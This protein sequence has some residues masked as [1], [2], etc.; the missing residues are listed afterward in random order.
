MWEVRN[1]DKGRREWRRITPTY[2]GSTLVS[3]A[4]RSP[5]IGSPPRM[6]EVHNHR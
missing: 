5:C 2:V 1:Q 4:L 3:L 6:W